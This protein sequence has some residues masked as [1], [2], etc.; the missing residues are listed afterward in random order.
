[1]SPLHRNGT[2]WSGPP[3]RDGRCWGSLDVAQNAPT[4]NS[5]RHNHRGRLVVS[6]VE[7]TGLWSEEALSFTPALAKA[8]ARSGGCCR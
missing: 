8:R 2:A 3:V 5:H 6:A 7:V 1:M 4:Q